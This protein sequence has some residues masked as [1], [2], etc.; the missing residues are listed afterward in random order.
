MN[1]TTRAVSISAGSLGSRHVDATGNATGGRDGTADGNVQVNGSNGR[2]GVSPDRRR[3]TEATDVRSRD[4]AV[5]GRRSDREEG[6]R[7]R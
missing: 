4:A 2:A 3:P 6:Y 5:P 7:R 1:T